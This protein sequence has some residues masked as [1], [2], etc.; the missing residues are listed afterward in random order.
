M[1]SE[2]HLYIVSH[3]QFN[4]SFLWTREWVSRAFLCATRTSYTFH[5][6]PSF[7]PLSFFRMTVWPCAMRVP[8][9][10]VSILEFHSNSMHAVKCVYKHEHIHSTSQFSCCRH[11]CYFIGIFSQSCFFTPRSTSIVLHAHK[12]ISLHC[13][14]RNQFREWESEKHIIYFIENLFN[15]D[16]FSCKSQIIDFARR[17]HLCRC[18]RC[19]QTSSNNR[20]MCIYKRNGMEWDGIPHFRI[21]N[22]Y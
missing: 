1:T 7:S 17:H 12:H 15:F 19:R 2:M 21:Y 20:R 8:M 14:T 9:G 13:V 11:S 22:M 3:R 18:R 5:F 16:F 6:P 10:R 4:M